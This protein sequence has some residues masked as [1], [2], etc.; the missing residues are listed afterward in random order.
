MFERVHRPIVFLALSASCVG[1]IAHASVW[2]AVAASCMLTA[3]SLFERQYSANRYATFHRGISDPVLVLSS[4]LN[5][6]TFSAAAFGFGLWTRWVW[7]L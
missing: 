1:G 6:A 7:G 4:V 2:I 3:T 5:A